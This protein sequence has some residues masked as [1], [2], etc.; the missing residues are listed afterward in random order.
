MTSKFKKKL[1]ISALLSCSYLWYFFILAIFLALI[2]RKMIFCL[3]SLKIQHLS[4]ILFSKY[5][6]AANTL[7]SSIQLSI[8][9]PYWRIK[10]TYY[11]FYFSLYHTFSFISNYLFDS[12]LSISRSFD[13]LKQ[14]FWKGIRNNCKALPAYRKSY[15]ISQRIYT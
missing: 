7:S 5:T 11:P 2:A 4:S 13:Y 12:L 9:K 14:L 6:K 3:L 15:L 8:W 1:K 10:T